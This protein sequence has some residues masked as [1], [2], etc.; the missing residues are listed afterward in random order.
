MEPG[1]A[2]ASR[3]LLCLANSEAWASHVVGGRSHPNP[4]GLGASLLFPF[5]IRRQRFW[6]LCK[7][8][9]NCVPSFLRRAAKA[10]MEAPSNLIL[11]TCASRAD[12]CGVWTP[13]FVRLEGDRHTW[14]NGQAPQQSRRNARVKPPRQPGV[15][16]APALAPA[17]LPEDPPRSRRTRRPRHCT[18]FLHAPPLSHPLG[19]PGRLPRPS[20]DSV[21]PPPALGAARAW[22]AAAGSSPRSSP[23]SGQPAAAWPPVMD[24]RL[25]LW[26]AGAGGASLPGLSRE[27]PYIRALLTQ[28]SRFH[29]MAGDIS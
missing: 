2:S 16:A 21:R 8:V 3:Q 27:T 1:V 15:A 9:E 12:K 17:A 6:L 11:G 23:A 20:G 14:E 4:A 10:W 28:R 25:Q 5:E 24:R 13:G 26:A 29:S 7:R 22:T 19:A 18:A